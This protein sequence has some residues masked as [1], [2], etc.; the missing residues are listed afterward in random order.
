MARSKVEKSVR[1]ILKRLDGALAPPAPGPKIEPA[2]RQLDIA[3][4][5]SLARAM[6]EPRRRVPADPKPTPEPVAAPPKN[7]R[8]VYESIKATNRLAAATYRQKF[9]RSIDSDEPKK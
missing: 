3:E 9:A 8:A 4:L 1:K 5:A 7:H 6:T 2:P